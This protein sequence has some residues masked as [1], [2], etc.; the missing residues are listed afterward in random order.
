MHE[1]KHGMWETFHWCLFIF[2]FTY[3]IITYCSDIE[4]IIDWFIYFKPRDLV[5]SHYF[6][7]VNNNLNS[8]TSVKHSSMRGTVLGWLAEL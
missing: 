3:Y 1:L 2:L 5:E 4:T 7:A 8:N 6:S